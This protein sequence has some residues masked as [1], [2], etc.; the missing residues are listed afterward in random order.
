MNGEM[1][2]GTWPLG[3]QEQEV[4]EYKVAIKRSGTL[5]VS[6]CDCMLVN[7]R[8]FP[9]AQCNLSKDIIASDTFKVGGC[10]GHKPVPTKYL[11][12][13]PTT[14]PTPSPTKKVGRKENPSTQDVRPFLRIIH[15]FFFRFSLCS[16]HLIPRIIQPTSQ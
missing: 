8:L 3:K 1:A 7:G 12:K 15:F 4:M 14:K 16:P 5:N 9:D 2:Y 6:C 13:K 10:S 11:T